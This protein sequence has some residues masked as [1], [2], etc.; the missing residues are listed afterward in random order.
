MRDYIF[1]T[2]AIALV[3]TLGACSTNG[4]SSQS[5]QSSQIVQ[6]R[7]CAPG[8]KHP[9]CMQLAQTQPLGAAPYGLDKSSP[10][11]PE[12]EDD[13]TPYPTNPALSY[14]GPSPSTFPGLN[15]FSG[16]GG[17]HIH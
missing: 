14:T 10:T 12:M 7:A 15:N 6:R 3:L 13:H 1:P 16:I 9:W 17:M 4:Q 8:E 2:I 11:N 5:R